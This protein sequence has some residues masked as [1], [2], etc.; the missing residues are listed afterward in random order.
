MCRGRRGVTTAA[1]GA[2]E[3][4]SLAHNRR[5]R[6]IARGRGKHCPTASFL[7]GRPARSAT[8]GQPCNVTVTCCPSVKEPAGSR[9]SCGRAV[10][11]RGAEEDGH[12][13]VR[14]RIDGGLGADVDGGNDFHD[15]RLRAAV[16]ELPVCRGEEDGPDGQGDGEGPLGGS[17]AIWERKRRRSQMPVPF[18]HSAA[19]DEAEKWRPRTVMVLLFAEPAV[20]CHGDGRA[21]HCRGRY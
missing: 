5:T 20:W 16:V 19:A 21:G 2:L 10:G 7:I 11:A 18:T 12:L 15:A 8:P 13:D 17:L 9:V 1:V 3:A 14:G 4:R 6:L